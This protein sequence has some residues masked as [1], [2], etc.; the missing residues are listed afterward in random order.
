MDPSDA[1]GVARCVYRCHG[2]T[3]LDPVMYRPRLLRGALRSGLVH[4]LVAVTPEGEIVGHIALSWERAGDLVPEGGKLVVDP[5]YRGHHLA[6]RLA[7]ELAAVAVELGLSGVWCECVT[8]HS[9]S[10]K[11][12]LAGGGAE[13]G[14]LIGATPSSVTMAA[15]GNTAQGRHSLLTMWT[16][17][18][19]IAAATR[20]NG[21]A[22]AVGRARSVR[23]ETGRGV[24]GTGRFEL[25]TPCSQSRCATKLRHVPYEAHYRSRP[26]PPPPRSESD[27]RWRSPAGDPLR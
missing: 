18:A 7:E 6:E 8:N 21:T 15:L 23:D 11:E 12:V 3:Y 9:H 13:T 17:V 26:G 14:L 10:Q 4:A 27:A 19:G 22:F 1:L 25:P 20:L 5:R 2:Y 16:P 24:V